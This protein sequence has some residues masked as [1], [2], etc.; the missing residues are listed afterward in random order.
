[1]AMNQN[2]PY[3]RPTPASLGDRTA[4]KTMADRPP[5]YPQPK[6]TH[7]PGW[8][9]TLVRSET[10]LKLRALQKST[11]DP[12]I[13]MSYLTDACLQLALEMG[14]DVIVQRALD[15]ICPARTTT[16]T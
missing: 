8:K 3:L 1:M 10:F 16:L 4:T 14:G 13:D 11:T 12:A 7:R 9:A 2:P 15:G 6:R 5:A